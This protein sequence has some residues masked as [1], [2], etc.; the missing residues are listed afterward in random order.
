MV[1][2][3]LGVVL[4]TAL[5]TSLVAACGG[6]AATPTAAPAAPKAAEPTK[7]PAVAAAPT[8]APAP[9]PTAAPTAVPK[10]AFP[11]KGRSITI[12][13]A[14]PAGSSS[15][16]LLRLA[17]SYL[18]KRL[19]VPVNVVAKPGAG[20]QTGITELA[21]SKPDGYT[22]A[23]NS[24]PTTAILYLDP[25]RKAAFNR[26]S[27]EPV[28]QLVQDPFSLA[29]KGGGKYK[30]TKDLIDAAKAN[31]GKINV[32]DGGILTPG[33]LGV[34]TLAKAAAVQ[35]NSVHFSGDT[36][37]YAALFGDNIDATIVSG[38]AAALGHYKSGAMRI[39]G[40]MDNERSQFFPDV[41][42]MK[43]QGF[44]VQTVSSR[45]VVAPAGVPKEVMD[46]YDQAFSAISKDP[47]YAKKALEAG[48]NVKYLGP[49]DHAKQW[50]EM[51]IQVKDALA[52]AKAETK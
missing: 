26:N 52:A 41:Q 24:M 12:I 44:P 32:G 51:E 19:E 29:V 28:C 20:S 50:D 7:A 11:E 47:D 31:P 15:D 39:V 14:W 1:R 38:A 36:E 21:Q 25:A 45:A 37:A 17:G 46:I 8:T 43:E 9:A 3:F 30:T 13:V 16:L 40:V 5:L 27:F 23:H 2:R 35:F 4:I 49:A 42:T 48:F 33:H 6:G 10:A 34:I 18:E 22:I